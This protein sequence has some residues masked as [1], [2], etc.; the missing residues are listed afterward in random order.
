MKHANQPWAAFLQDA[1]ADPEWQRVAATFGPR[2][3]L[4]RAVAEY[5]RILNARVAATPDE[6]RDAAATLAVFEEM[7]V[8]DADEFLALIERANFSKARR[9]R[10]RRPA[11]GLPGLK[12]QEA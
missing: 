3:P 6:L 10:K 2:T 11:P 7:G 12:P 4:S 1:N 9:V 8:A 5:I